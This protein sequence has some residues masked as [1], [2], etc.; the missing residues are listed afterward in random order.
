MNPVPSYARSHAPPLVGCT[1]VRCSTAEIRD[2][3]LD[4]KSMKGPEDLYSV[5]VFDRRG[6]GNHVCQRFAGT[7][8]LPPDEH[9]MGQTA[10]GSDPWR[11][12]IPNQGVEWAR[13][14]RDY[15][16]GILSLVFRYVAFSFSSFL[17]PNAPDA[18]PQMELV[19][20][21]LVASVYFSAP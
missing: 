6:T 15:R 5:C 17:F 3:Q 19:L 2:S 14:S 16:N 21:G 7:S 4:R 8:D 12:Q 9:T 18:L 10:D 1:T 11:V 13:V 20:A